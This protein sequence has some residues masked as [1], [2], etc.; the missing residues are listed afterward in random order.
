MNI[1]NYDLRTNTEFTLFEFKSNGPKGEIVKGIA[2]SA[3]Q[4][5][6]LY[7]LGFG[8]LFFDPIKNGFVINDLIVSDNADRNAVL[9]TV[10]KSA[11]IFTE[12]YPNRSVFFKGSTKGRTR[13]YRRAISINLKELS[14]TFHIFGAMKDENG[15]ILD[16]PFD[17]NGDFYGFIIKRKLK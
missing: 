6:V 14:E 5:E 15:A 11:Y 12:K 8:D 7:N 1:P 10:A 9:A 13:L 4:S 17:S 2:Y 16:I 3:I